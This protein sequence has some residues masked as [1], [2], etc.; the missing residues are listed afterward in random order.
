MKGL[1]QLKKY[2]CYR[3]CKKARGERNSRITDP[4]FKGIPIPIQ[5]TLGEI[6]GGVGQVLFPDEF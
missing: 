6:G 2:V 4:L 1:V 5:L 3:T